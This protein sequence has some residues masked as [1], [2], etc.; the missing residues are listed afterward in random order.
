LYCL[1]YV[2][3]AIF[4]SIGL[5]SHRLLP[6]LT[7]GIDMRHDKS[8][9]F[10]INDG[11]AVRL[12]CVRGLT[13]T[14][15]VELE[16]AFKERVGEAVD[17]TFLGRFDRVETASSIGEFL[18]LA[19]EGGIISGSTGPCETVDSIYSLTE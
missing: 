12:I 18:D 6:S 11:G 16:K 4:V 19:R 3:L 10:Q 14:G 1:P 9:V 8:S 5:Y 15:G 17:I 2:S 7:F 13:F